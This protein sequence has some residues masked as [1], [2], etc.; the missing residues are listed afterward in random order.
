MR[1]F[2]TILALAVGTANAAIPTSASEYSYNNLSGHSDAAKYALGTMLR[3]AHTRLICVYSFATSGGAL[4]TI[5]LKQT[6]LKTDCTI[7]AKSIVYD[8]LIDVITAPTSASAAYL[9][10]KVIAAGDL[11]ADLAKA[12]WTGLLDTIPVNTAAT[13]IKIASAK[14]ISVVISSGSLTGGKFRVFLDYALSE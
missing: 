3:E 14:T 12:S 8:G 6:D 4:G 5:S 7:P 2:L 9:N 11:K 10:L 13:A 1:L